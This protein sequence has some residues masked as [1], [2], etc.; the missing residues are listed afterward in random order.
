MARQGLFETDNTSLFLLKWGLILINV[1]FWAMG[2][3]AFGLGMWLYIEN[4][5]YAIF[6]D[7]E[8]L[9]G[10]VLLL[11]CGFSVI[12][13]GFL[14]VVAALFE[15]KLMT[16]TYTALLIMALILYLSAG[17]WA[18]A[19]NDED[20]LRSE[21]SRFLNVSLDEYITNGQEDFV[22]AWDDMQSE[23]QCCGSSGSTSW[24][25]VAPNSEERRSIPDS[26]CVQ[27][28]PRCA[29]FV[30]ERL[31]ASG[32]VDELVA[33]EQD[34]LDIIG[35]VGIT[36]GIVQVFGVIICVLFIILLFS[37]KDSYSTN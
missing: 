13:V 31:H 36:F 28:R 23:L 19:N 7:G 34:Q 6:S 18:V 10:S 5:E 20:E 24:Y 29:T 15:S 25:F 4:N 26:C 30:N 33:Y 9:P 16:F 22:E 17:I 3:T 35:P 21:I 14:G 8:Y 27:R 12:I 2:V 11:A 1:L 32:C 37:S